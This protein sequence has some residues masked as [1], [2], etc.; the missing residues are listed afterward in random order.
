[1]RITRLYLDTELKES[2]ECEI[3]GETAH[4]VINVLR[5]QSGQQLVLFNGKGGQYS[6]EILGI[7]KNRV[8]VGVNDHQPAER[9]SS[10]DITLV[11]G[12]SRGQRMDYAI[13][14]SVELGVT[15]LV[16]VITEFSSI[17]LNINQTEKKNNHWK[18]IIINAC[19]QC[20][21]NKIPVLE[22]VMEI[23]KWFELDTNKL[24][25]ILHPESGCRF[26]DISRPVDK[27][28]LLTGP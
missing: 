2:M 18:K 11:Q 25:I 14:K 26:Q 20:G 13:Q 17:K 3:S 23:S 21:R 8:V 5:M 10:L 28:T 7:K 12:I 9:E 1:M 4:Y 27:F 6:A 24:K 15:R 16:P 22:N 19:E